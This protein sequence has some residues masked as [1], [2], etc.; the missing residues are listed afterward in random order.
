MSEI[1]SMPVRAEAQRLN[2]LHAVEALAQKVVFQG[3][4]GS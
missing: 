1:E 4:E 2:L 3:Q